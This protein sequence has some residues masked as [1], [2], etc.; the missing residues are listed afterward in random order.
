MALYASRSLINRDS[1]LC[2][3]G[4]T[5]CRRFVGP[6]GYTLKTW[7]TRAGAERSQKAWIESGTREIVEL[8][9]EGSLPS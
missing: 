7:K 9:P 1:L 4:E 5:H 3:D 2:Q 6:G 8:T